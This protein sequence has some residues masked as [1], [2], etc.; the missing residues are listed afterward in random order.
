MLEDESHGSRLKLA[1]MIIVT[2]VGVEKYMDGAAVLA[3][4]ISMMRSQHSCHMVAVTPLGTQFAEARSVLH[5]LGYEVRARPVPVNLS[6]IRT[7]RA[8]K[9]VQ[10]GCCGLNELLKVCCTSQLLAVSAPHCHSD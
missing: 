10:G 5:M 6:E 9:F 1:F 8:R 3:H 2:S 7:A 4:S